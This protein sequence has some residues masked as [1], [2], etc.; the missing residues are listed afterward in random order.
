MI[1]AIFYFDEFRLNL[2]PN[3]RSCFLVITRTDTLIN[4]DTKIQI[5]CDLDI[6]C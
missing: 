5:K 3:C 4:P 1:V 6:V 2:S